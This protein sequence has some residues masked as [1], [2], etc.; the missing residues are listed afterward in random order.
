[1][2]Q[3]RLG[4]AKVY[5]SVDLSSP[6]PKVVK[7][8]RPNGELC[9]VEVQYS[10]RLV[11]CLFCGNVGHET[12]ACRFKKAAGN[13]S[14]K[15]RTSGVVIED[16]SK[17]REKWFSGSSWR[18]QGVGTESGQGA[19]APSCKGVQS[20][21]GKEVVVALSESD[22][23]G[24]G[25][26]DLQAEVVRDSLDKE[27]GVV[28]P[29]HNLGVQQNPIISNRERRVRFANQDSSIGF[30][31]QGCG[32][33]GDLVSCLAYEATAVNVK[34]S[35]S[36]L[37]DSA[38][39]GSEDRASQLNLVRGL[40]NV[41]VNGNECIKSNGGKNKD[42]EKEKSNKAQLNDRRGS[43]SHSVL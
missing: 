37:R 38:Q 13:N 23:E 10:L 33:Q 25:N 39:S 17:D 35:S 12:D 2:E 31:E 15:P 34:D 18:K 21:K 9:L 20:N 42:K 22:V 26:S 24:V 1:M 43:S 5:I 30:S 4:F 29:G 3:D 40:S 7:V 6:P 14:F 16:R 11:R 36:G 41:L 8:R 32:V 19:L 28:P 27:N